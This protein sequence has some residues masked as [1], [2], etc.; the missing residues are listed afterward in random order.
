MPD[1]STVQLGRRLDGKVAIITG[2]TKGIGYAIAE[3]FLSEG[4]RVVVTSRK[5][6]NVDEAVSS[7]Q[8]GLSKTSESRRIMGIACHVGKDD[9]R[10]RLV[11]SVVKKWGVVDIL[12]N[13]AAVSPAPGGLAT[14]SES[15]WDKLFEINVK[16]GL[17]LLQLCLPHMS[18]ERDANVLFVSSIA[19]YNPMAPL[20]AYGITKVR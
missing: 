14:I 6:K 17:M 1:L 15:I 11:D 8:R 18:G 2:S 16:A 3:R 19:A 5:Q 10:R 13:N 12:V 4:C 20:S 9:Q 7:L